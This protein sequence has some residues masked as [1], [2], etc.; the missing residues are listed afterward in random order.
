[1]HLWSDPPSTPAH[2][3]RRWTTLFFNRQPINVTFNCLVF[4]NLDGDFLS[5][6]KQNLIT[7]GSTCVLGLILNGKL[8]VA[9]VGDSV[10]T[11]VKRDGSWRQVNTEHAA[12]RPDEMARIENAKGTVMN[13]RV[14]GILSVSRAFGDFEHKDL[15]IAEPETYTSELAADDDML[16]LSSDGIYRSYTREYV[17]QRASEL[18]RQGVSLGTIAETIVEEALRLE[19]TKKPCKD[20]VT[21]M[22]VSLRDYL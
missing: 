4:Q 13:S 16:I 8:T 6:A 12:T 20:N 11:L 21:L 14:N 15:I 7:D 3:K 2:L 17:A 1:M 9:N 19:N 22:I 18:R 5:H 10:A